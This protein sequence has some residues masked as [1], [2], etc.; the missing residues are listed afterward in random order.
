MAAYRNLRV[1]E[2]MTMASKKQ[3][4]TPQSFNLPTVGVETHA[5]LDFPEYSEDLD[6]VLERAG[7]A[8][9]AWIGQIFLSTAAYHI[10]RA[11]LGAR[12][13]MFFTLGI[14]PHEATSVSSSVLRDMARLFAADP[15]LRAV[16]RPAHGRH[17]RGGGLL[18]D[19]QP[20]LSRAYGLPR[21]AHLPGLPRDRRRYGAA[22]R[23]H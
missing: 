6:N 19:G 12:Q 23:H 13:G 1:K 7:Q 10:H 8:G 5:H 20:Q 17:R 11:V 21:G 22:R 16:H 3:I 18:L 15:G 14:H 2:N 9:I 4:P